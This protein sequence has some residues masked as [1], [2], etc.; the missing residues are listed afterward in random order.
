MTVAA[1]AVA[2]RAGIGEAG[3]TTSARQET[4]RVT[5]MKGRAGVRLGM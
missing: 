4:S 2:A 5:A 3:V 1:A